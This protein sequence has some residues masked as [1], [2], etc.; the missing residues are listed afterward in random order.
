MATRASLATAV[1][2]R[3]E[4]ALNRLGAVDAAVAEK[5]R[6]DLELVDEFVDRMVAVAPAVSPPVSES[7]GRPH[8][9]ELPL[10]HSTQAWGAITVAWFQAV[11]G[12]LSPTVQEILDV[13]TED[14]VRHIWAS[15]MGDPVLHPVE[16]GDYSLFT[17]IASDSSVSGEETNVAIVN[18]KEVG[19]HEGAPGFDAITW[20]TKSFGILFN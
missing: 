2:K 6:H 3:V 4:Y 11:T 10:L 14:E 5:V 20:A 17:G 9:P 12:K 8:W 13:A 1:H 19:R 18:G 7:T 15:A 16:G